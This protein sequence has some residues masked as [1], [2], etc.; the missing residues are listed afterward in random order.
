MTLQEIRWT[1]WTG[2]GRK[3]LKDGVILYSGKKRGK[4]EGTGFYVRNEIYHNVIEF[5]GINSRLA[6]LRLSSKWFII[7]LIAVHAPTDV[8][9]D[10]LKDTWYGKLQTTIDKVPR[11]DILILIG[12]FNAKVGR[13]NGVFGNTVGSHSLHEE[14]TDNGIRLLS[15]TS[16][17]GMVIGGSLFPHR[18]I[19]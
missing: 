5:E 2:A 16:Q 12:D 17:N 11:H 4:H 19:H 8:S 13:E 6:R 14:S 7:T 10:R 18:N 9:E 15:M 1:H 3:D